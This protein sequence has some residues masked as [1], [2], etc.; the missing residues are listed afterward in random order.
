M[1]HAQVIIILIVALIVVA[2][3]I[4]NGFAPYIKQAIAYGKERYYYRKL[5]A[6]NSKEFWNAMTRKNFMGA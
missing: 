4:Y 1:K 6:K 3:T 5:A 2:T